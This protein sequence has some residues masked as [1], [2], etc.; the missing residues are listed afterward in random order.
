[1]Q[2][3]ESA[4][5]E[6]VQLYQNSKAMVANTKA[7]YVQ[8]YLEYEKVQKENGSAKDIEKAEIKMKKAQLDYKAWIEKCQTHREDYLS[9]MTDACRV[10]AFLDYIL[11]VVGYPLFEICKPFIYV[12]VYYSVS[13]TWRPFT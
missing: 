9:K 1:V 4:T 5:I 3:E 12:R 6:A 13:K 7:S 11:G 10:N 2:D 8:R